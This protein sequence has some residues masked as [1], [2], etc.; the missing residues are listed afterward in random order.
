MKWLLLVFL[1]LTSCASYSIKGVNVYD[2][3]VDTSMSERDGKALVSYAMNVM[4]NNKLFD[5][6]DFVFISAW[7]GLEMPDGRIAVADGRTDHLNKVIYLKVHDCPWHSA[8]F[9]EMGHVIRLYESGNKD[10]GHEDPMWDRVKLIEEDAIKRYCPSDY[11][12]TKAA[13]KGLQ[14]F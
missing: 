8:I 7:L 1:M 11:D 5:S 4:G 6:W 13:P 2:K 10:F 3:Q 12:V 9:H 14:R